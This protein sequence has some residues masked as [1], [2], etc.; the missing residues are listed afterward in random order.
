MKVNKPHVL[1]VLENGVLV[2]V[3]SR[4]EVMKAVRPIYGERLNVVERELESA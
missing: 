2:G 1:P 3:L 4:A